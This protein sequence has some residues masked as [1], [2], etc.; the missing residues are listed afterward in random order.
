MGSSP[1][2]GATSARAWSD[3]S[4]ELPA[5][6]KAASNY[7]AVLGMV[8][9]SL[10][11]LVA[12]ASGSGGIPLVLTAIGFALV[13]AGPLL[14][15]RFRAEPL[16]DVMLAWGPDAPPA[17]A[18]PLLRDQLAAFHRYVGGIR[19][20]PC[21]VGASARV[22]VLREG[23]LTFLSFGRTIRP[24]DSHVLRVGQDDRPGRARVPG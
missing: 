20:I 22:A 12:L 14:V 5:A 4:V 1:R 16:Y 24:N 23:A 21:G 17:D 6:R 11:A 9:S 2:T 8:L 3:S 13:V 15:S 18:G 7:I 10:V 19:R